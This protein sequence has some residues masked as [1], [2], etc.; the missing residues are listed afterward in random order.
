MMV[1][2]IAKVMHLLPTLVHEC[3]ANSSQLQKK[4]IIIGGTV[5]LGERK[6]LGTEG[7][8]EIVEKKGN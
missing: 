3:F 8:R 2:R 4:N 7:G 5:E 6:G 1:H